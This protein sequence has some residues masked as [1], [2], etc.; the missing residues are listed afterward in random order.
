[1]DGGQKTFKNDGHHSCTFPNQEGSFQ[2]KPVGK[3]QNISLSI[4]TIFSF[5]FIILRLESL[6]IKNFFMKG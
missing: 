6:S 1:M 4:N 3:F 2:I 5:C